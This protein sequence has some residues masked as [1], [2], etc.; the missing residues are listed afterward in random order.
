MLIERRWVTAE[1]RREIERKIERKIRKHGDVRASL[2]AVAGADARDAIGAVD[3]PEIRNSLSSLPPAIGHVLLETLVPPREPGDSRYTLTRMHAEGGLGRVWLARDRDLRRGVALKEIRPD[4]AANPEL[5]RRFLKEAQITSQLEH[6]NIVPV[7]E[8]AR[9]REDDQPFYTMRFVRGQSLLG[10]IRE[11]HRRRAGKAPDQ[12]ALQ[13]L[14]GAFLKVCDAIAYAHSRGVIHRDLK[15]ENIVLGGYGEVVVL[16][17]GLSKLM[18]SPDEPSEAS[19]EGVA[20]ISLSTEARAD[21]THG[22][23]G[24]PCYMAPEQVQAR[25]D[26]IDART[27][28]YAMGGILFEI[29]TGHPPAEGATT[30]EV[31]ELIRSARIPRAR[32][33]EPAVPRA[34][35]SVCAKAMALDRGERYPGAAELAA[36]IRRWIADLP[37]TAYREPL[38][39]RARRWMRRH[40]TLTA[41]V[42]AAMLM[43][44]AALGILY[45]REAA[46]SAGLARINHSLDQANGRLG[47]A[48]RSLDI[49]NREFDRERKRA[50]EREALAIDAMTKFRDAVANNPALKTRPELESLRK[51]LLKE[52]LEFFRKLRDQLKADAGREPKAV[53]E[54]AAANYAL[55]R[56]TREIGSVSDAIQSF[57]EVVA[58]L[59]PLARENPAVTDYQ[60]NLAAVR[61]EMGNLLSATGRLDD[62]LLAYRAAMTT[63]ESLDIEQAG[64]TKH[65]SQRADP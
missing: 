53:L 61:G 54:L 63:F 58:L 10:A 29:L 6:P 40:R 18:D 38:P 25:H 11:F 8:L 62:A 65:M 3:H 57:S 48:N 44:L 19:D 50:E 26:H 22:L 56:T 31:L 20:R 52:P 43:T 49:R 45:R 28:V 64:R 17:W 36:E 51:A 1:D 24:T 5:W 27:D 9:R 15:P 14:L 33:V 60:V 7:Y 32:Q 13:T 55:A 16:D 46:Y 42:A 12:L 30:A 2:A 34:L 4:R 41:A 47:E 23:L 35:E 39:A 37:V 21:Q 59:E